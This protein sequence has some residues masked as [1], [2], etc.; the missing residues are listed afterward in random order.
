M[1]SIKSYR[2]LVLLL[3][4]IA[5]GAGSLWYTRDLVD[6]LKREE[7]NKVELWAKATKMIV[8]ADQEQDL[9]FFFS[10]IENNNTVPVILTN[11]D[12]SII[13]SVNFDESKL[14][15]PHYLEGQLE[16]MKTRN[17]PITID[18]GD[19][20]SNIIYYKDSTILTQLIYFP[21]IQLGVI[22]LFILIAYLAFN[23]AK[24]AEENQIWASLTKETAHQ[25]GTPT[26]SLGGWVEVLNDRYPDDEVSG[27]IAL[28]VERLEKITERFSRIGTKP[29]LKKENIIP[30]FTGT[31]GYLKKRVSSKIDF[32]TNFNSEEVVE[33]EFNGALFEWVIEN[34]SKNSVDA[35]GGEGKL[36]Y[37]LLT[38]PESVVIDI[39]DTGKGMPKKI[40]KKIFKPGFT[41]KQHGWGLGLSLAKRIV[42]EFHGGKLF[43]KES[44]LGKGTTMRIILKRRG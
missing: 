34:I 40:H 16:K 33:T 9:D 3:L 22:S 28:D 26:S 2:R 37:T 20:Y 13:A 43:V 17:E 19:G 21:Y 35:M 8:M 44:E 27:E 18:L 38:T 15:D 7:R 10:I 4:A 25:L 42:E 23:S 36:S 11:G 29:V 30:I 12:D 24:K 39:T 1:K 6:V 41:T 14:S 5:I 32:S 31:I